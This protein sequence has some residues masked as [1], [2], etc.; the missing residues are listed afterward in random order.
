MGRAQFIMGGAFPEQ[1]VLGSIWKQAEQA[2]ASKPG[3]RIPA[4]MGSASD[5]WPAGILVLTS[6]SDE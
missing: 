1:V 5:C 3:S 4:T 6:F 2:M